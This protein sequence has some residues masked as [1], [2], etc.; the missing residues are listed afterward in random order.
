[1]LA[2]VTL[3]QTWLEPHGLLPVILQT[4]GAAIVVYAALHDIAART[5]PNKAPAFLIAFGLTLRLL[6]H[7]FLPGLG[8]A[9]AIFVLGVICWWRGWLGG[10]DV[11]LLPAGA[12]LLPPVL[13][14]LF[15]GAVALAG[16][17]LAVVYWT[18]GKI[19][20]RRPPPSFRLATQHRTLWRRAL[21]AE[22]WRLVRGIPLPYATAIAAGFLFTLFRT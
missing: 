16:G 4:T 20:Q 6:T 14:P 1:M 8:W 2:F 15:L 5:V 11:K 19:A 9:S 18:L 22:R 21:N 7:T 12:L 13:C 17:V 3:S 10:G